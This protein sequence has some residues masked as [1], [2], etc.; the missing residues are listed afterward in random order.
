LNSPADRIPNAYDEAGRAHAYAD[1]G[2]AGTYYLAFRD[3]PAL[4]ARHV[5]GNRALD[6]G[7]G[8]GRYTRLLQQLGFDTVGIDIAEPM[9]QLARE[10]DPQ[11]TYLLIEDDAATGWPDGPFD[12]V[13]AAYPFDNIADIKHRRRLLAA[14]RARLSS[15]GRLVLIASAPELY[16]HEWLSFTTAYP[17]N[18][19]ARTGDI[20]RIAI[21]DGTDPRAI[22]DV[23]WDDAAYRADFAAVGL[24]VLET[25]HPLGRADEPYPWSTEMEV[26]PWLIYACGSAGTSRNATPT[27]A[28]T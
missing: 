22:Q 5:S 9:L 12:L 17:E 25:L 23:L 26:S 13:L 21:T 11:G 18:A 6:F 15:R 19:S 3:V 28:E 4:I 20:V 8:A 27:T 24:S 2:F 14:I 7:C 10:R 16:A 1:L